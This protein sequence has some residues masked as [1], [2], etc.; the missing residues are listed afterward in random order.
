MKGVTRYWPVRPVWDIIWGHTVEMTDRITAP[1]AKKPSRGN[2]SWRP[3]HVSAAVYLL[4]TWVQSICQRLTSESST[5][6]LV[7]HLLIACFTGQTCISNSCCRNSKLT[8]PLA[9]SSSILLLLLPNNTWFCLSTE[10]WWSLIGMN[11]F[12]L[13]QVV[14]SVRNGLRWQIALWPTSL[15]FHSRLPVQWIST[16]SV[17]VWVKQ[18]FTLYW[19]IVHWPCEHWLVDEE[20]NW[21]WLVLPKVIHCH[22]LIALSVFVR[23]VCIIL[24]Q[25]NG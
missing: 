6:A 11:L 16:S 13:P 22:Y 8:V 17:N 25:M 4:I 10:D 24:F 19:F 15:F 18:Y 9:K 5:N 23:F 7:T 20:G 1:A 14:V 2:Q 12:R 21:H 3:G